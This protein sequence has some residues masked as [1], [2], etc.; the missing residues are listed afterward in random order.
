MVTY[1]KTYRL[2]T[3]LVSELD[4]PLSWLIQLDITVPFFGNDMKKALMVHTQMISKCCGAVAVTYE[5]SRE[6]VCTNCHR[7]WGW[8]SWT[9]ALSILMSIDAKG[10]A[11]ERRDRNA[12]FSKEMIKRFNDGLPLDTLEQTLLQEILVNE[13]SESLYEFANELGRETSEDG[14]EM[15][16]SSR[17]DTPVITQYHTF[18]LS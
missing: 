17:N 13:I 18:V 8:G 7:N 11:E 3:Q 1:S 4:I 2:N 6:T 5:H 16:I 14:A 12:L 15:L 10:A 9:N